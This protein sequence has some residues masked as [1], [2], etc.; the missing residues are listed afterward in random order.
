LDI[1]NLIQRDFPLIDNDAEYTSQ[2][3]FQQVGVGGTRVLKGAYWSVCE[4]FRE[5]VLV[6]IANDIE[7]SAQS[8]LVPAFH[9]GDMLGY[10]MFDVI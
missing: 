1:L 4:K 6:A 3:T 8:N 7:R 5:E 10:E 9:Q 2:A